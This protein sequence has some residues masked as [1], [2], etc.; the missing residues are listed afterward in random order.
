MSQRTSRYS[1]YV[2]AVLLC[3]YSVNWMD[4]YVLIILLEPIKRDL[5]LSDTALG[6]LSGFVFATI[7]SLAGIPIARL[8]DRAVRRT[9]IATGLVVW[10]AMTTLSGL[11][12]SFA[13]LV[14]ARFGV[15]LGESACSPAASSLIADYFP[16]ERRATA[17]AIYGVGITIGMALGLAVGGWANELY[18]W[19][20][21]FFV[22]GLP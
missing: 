18:G 21:A 6:L 9:V 16:A 19:R 13:Q 3:V 5:K 8:A 20:A 15:A 17:F 10:S 2:L 14:A 22:T 4:R 7:Y 11:A 12:A 1:W